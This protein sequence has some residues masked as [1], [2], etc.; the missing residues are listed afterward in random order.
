MRR[1]KGTSQAL[2]FLLLFPRSTVLVFLL[3]YT[4]DNPVVNS[5]FT[6]N[7]GASERGKA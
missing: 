5:G 2:S 4:Q 1:G 6:H 3:D 7:T